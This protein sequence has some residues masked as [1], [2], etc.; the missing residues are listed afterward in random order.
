MIIWIDEQLTSSKKD[1]NNCTNEEDDYD[2]NIDDVK[3]L[4]IVGDDYHPSVAAAQD[5]GSCH[6]WDIHS[7][8]FA[9]VDS[10]YSS[11]SRTDLIEA[12]T[13]TSI[14]IHVF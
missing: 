2:N 10:P 13:A 14:T 9:V 5:N 3:F 11:P 6:G 4:S 7:G 1:E 12:T 8:L